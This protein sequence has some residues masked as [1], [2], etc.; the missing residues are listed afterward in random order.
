MYQLLQAHRREVE[1]QVVDE[2]EEA[3]LTEVDDHEVVEQVPRALVAPNGK[4]KTT[5]RKM[6]RTSQKLSHHYLR[7]QDQ[8]EK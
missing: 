2:A 3:E 7:N 6:T 5:T 8:V 1:V 4:E